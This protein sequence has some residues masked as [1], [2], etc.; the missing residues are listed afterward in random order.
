MDP[1]LRELVEGWQRADSD[2]ERT[3]RERETRE[4]L[5]PAAEPADPD[6]EAMHR[7]AAVLDTA[8]D[9]AERLLR[10]HFAP[11]LPA[12]SPASQWRGQ[13]EP[14]PVLWRD[15]LVANRASE[16]A[17]D[18]VLSVGEVALLSAPGGSGKSYASLAL[19][20]AGAEA[21]DESGAALGL[22]VRA[23]PVVLVSYEDS[24]VRIAARLSR[25]GASEAAFERVYVLAEPSPLFVADPDRGEARPGLGWRALWQAVRTIRPALVV[26][27]PASAAL[28]DVSTSESAPVRAFMRE[29][30][31][32]AAACECGVLVVAHDTKAARNEAKAGGDPGAGAVAGSATWFDAARGVL[33]LRTGTDTMAAHRVLECIKS[34]HGARGWGAK[35]AEDVD[36]RG[37]FRGLRLTGHVT[38]EDMSATLRDL[39]QA[40]RK[41]RGNAA[42]DRAAGDDGSAAYV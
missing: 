30:A 37:G 10:E 20:R 18:T 36:Q 19:A 2:A 15:S 14:A 40:G 24:P 1:R 13:P 35:L 4:Y 32:E 7:A 27:D 3:D 39:H 23:G 41:S 42:A 11:A 22:R 9:E 5:T 21:D 25:M 12:V 6:R 31:R 8:P 38:R 16:Y 17:T 28:A 33:Y 26:V 34:N 29:L